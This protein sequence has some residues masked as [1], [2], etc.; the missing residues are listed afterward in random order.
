[1]KTIFKSTVLCGLIVLTLYSCEQK[2]LDGYVEGSIT[3]TFLCP[4]VVNEQAVDSIR[5]FCILLKDRENSTIT[6]YPMDLFT[7]N[8]PDGSLSL[9]IEIQ[10]YKYD[11][12]NCGP[13]FFSD[14]LISKYKCMIKYRYPVENELIG[15]VCG[16][17][18]AMA[19]GFPWSHFKQIIIEDI[20]IGLPEK[21]SL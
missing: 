15:F 4:K 14:S 17:C 6:Y 20:K 7:L 21:Y 19:A 2:N 3:G 18:S 11:G 16:P 5:G 13:K 8:L 9:P 1:M 12:S 10:N